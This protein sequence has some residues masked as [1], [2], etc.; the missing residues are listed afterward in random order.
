M[1]DPASLIPEPSAK[2]SAR[3]KLA[4]RIILGAGILSAGVVYWAASRAQ[5][6]PD[7][8]MMA[9]YSKVEDRQ[10]NIMYGKMG[11]TFHDLLADLERPGALAVIIIIF[12]I[13]IAL[14]CFRLAEPLPPEPPDKNNGTAS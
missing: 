7:D 11:S 5:T 6:D 2:A 10:L 8:P 1:N 4:G 9:G 14:V 3:L 12:S 13:L